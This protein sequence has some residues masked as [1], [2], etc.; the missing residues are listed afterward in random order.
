MSPAT[1]PARED[2][3]PVARP[4]G[5][6]GRRLAAAF[7]AISSMPALADAALAIAVMQ[8]A[9]NGNGPRGRTGSVHD[10][11]DGLRTERVAAI[12]ERMDTY[13][14]LGAAGSGSDRCERFRRHAMAV[15][16]AADRVGDMARV[17]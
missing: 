2:P 11:V 17:D 13:D 5:A 15:R 1:T 8:A 3:N 14:L 7:D 4:L 16:I 12:A 10:A 9:N 6:G